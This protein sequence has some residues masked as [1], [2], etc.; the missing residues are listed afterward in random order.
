MQSDVRL[1]SLRDYSPLSSH[2]FWAG[3]PFLTDDPV[4]VDLGH[5]ETYVFTQW[6]FYNVGAYINPS[7]QFSIL[8]NLGHSVAGQNHAIGY[9][10]L[11]YTF[12]RPSNP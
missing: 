4:P 8:V 12:P 2:S 1:Q 11:Y 7:S 9:F 5:Y 3:P 6:A 10:A